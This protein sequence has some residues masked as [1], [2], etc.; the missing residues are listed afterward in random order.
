[1]SS[2]VR[3]ARSSAFAHASGLPWSIRWGS[4][5]ES[6]KET[7]RARGSR[8]RR[9]TAD[10]LAIS[11]AA[12]PSQIWLELPAVTRP[13]G[14]NAGSSAASF[15]A[16]V[17]RRGVSSTANVVVAI[18]APAGCKSP[19]TSTGTISRSNLP[20]SIAAIARRCD[21]SEYSSS[22]ARVIPHS[23][24]IISAEIPCGT[25]CQR[26]CRRSERSPPFDPIG[27]RDIISTPAETTTSSWPDQ[28]AAAALKFVCIDD[29]HCRSTVVPLTVSGP[30]HEHRHPA[31]VPALLADLGHAAHL[32]VL[33]L[34]GLEPDPLDQPVE[35]LAGQLVPADGR[36]R[37]VAPPDR[38]PHGVDD[39]R[40][41]LPFA[42][43]TSLESHRG[44]ADERQDEAAEA[45]A[46]LRALLARRARGARDGSPTRSTSRKAS[47]S[48][49]RGP[50]AE[51]SS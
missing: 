20:A 7:K 50:R 4:T 39:Q 22:S 3:P 12:V 48:R 49:A 32:H 10:S 44:A 40:V 37:P 9:V 26:S 28:T 2:Q 23:S 38:R 29:P 35:H 21:S 6:P 19:A 31:H 1:M 27:T 36:E 16:D 47:S 34:A 14:R 5:P 17:S 51:S 8:P 18:A 11:T 42:H 33:D 43:A 13:S 41:G 24:A 25:I 15:S 30:R 46:A 45:G